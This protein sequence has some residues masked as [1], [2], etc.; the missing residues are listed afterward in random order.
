MAEIRMSDEVRALLGPDGA[1]RIERAFRSLAGGHCPVC[2]RDLPAEGPAN[3][4]LVCS[5][6]TTQAA[7]AHPA[8]TDSMV[9]RVSDDMLAQVLPDE[10]DM[11]VSALML[12]HA[13]ALLPVLV[14]ELPT[15]RAYH[16]QGPAGSMGELTDVLVSA[17]LE[18]GFDLVT[19]LREAPRR[20]ADCAAT[21]RAGT[22]A[23]VQLDIVGPG[24][25]LFYAGTA[26]PPEG[27]AE[28]TRR[29]GWCVLYA[30]PV[31]LGSAGEASAAL[32]ALRAAAGRGELVGARLPVTWEP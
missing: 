7:F 15:H 32:K 10:A 18:W 1:R 25:T 2:R 19:R 20:T 30:G 17:L 5:S 31:G 6:T 27:W 12:E 11:T 26:C 8:C 9:L 16:A 4:V 24:G 28:A 29:Y 3:V 13:R 21:V 23:A 14:A 22:G